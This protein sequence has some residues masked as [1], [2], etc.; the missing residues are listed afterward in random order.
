VVGTDNHTIID[1][2]R[3][4]DGVVDVRTATS[5][6]ACHGDVNPAPP[7]DLDGETR[8]S[9]AGV[10]AHQ[11]HLVGTGR[12]RTVPCETC[13]Q[14]PSKVLAAGH[15]DS[16]RPAEVVFSGIAELP[17]TTASYSR[18][19]C[20]NIA[21]HGAVWASGDDS[22]GT[23]TEPIWTKVDGTQNA[24]GTC[25]GLPPPHPHPQGSATTTCSDCHEDI[26]PDNA[27]FVR[28]D[29][30]VDGEVTFSVP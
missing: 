8:T 10:G 20:Q 22:A 12:S 16:M 9:A 30:H 1:L 15:I 29:L 7:R 24:C 27:T 14:V 11:T 19:A 2:N 18:G 5:C 17:G 25:H 26:S 6:T 4:V 28:P 3:H 21:C 23:I 13:H